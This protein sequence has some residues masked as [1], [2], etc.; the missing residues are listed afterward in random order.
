MSEPCRTSASLDDCLGVIL[1]T[2]SLQIM[3]SVRALV[4][5]YLIICSFCSAMKK[6]VG[7]PTISGII[8]GEGGKAFAEFL[9][10]EHAVSVV[11]LL[12][13]DRGLVSICGTFSTFR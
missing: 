5:F 10:V 4:S 3:S 1:A 2:G 9:H 12:P 6:V 8:C 13:V 7:S 11:F